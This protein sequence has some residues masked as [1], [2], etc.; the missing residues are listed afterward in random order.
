MSKRKN[1]MDE[2]VT[3]D[4]LDGWDESYKPIKKRCFCGYRG[5]LVADSLGYSCPACGY[6]L[7][8]KT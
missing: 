6:L 4:D 8:E 1:I 7:I 3:M 2:D 5:E